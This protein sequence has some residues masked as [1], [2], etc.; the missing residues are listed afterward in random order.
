MDNYSF[1]GTEEMSVHLFPICLLL[2]EYLLSLRRKA[3]RRQDML[4]VTTDCSIFSTS[5]ADTRYLLLLFGWY[6]I[7]CKY[8]WFSCTKELS[9]LKK[10]A[11]PYLPWLSPSKVTYLMSFFLLVSE[12]LNKVTYFGVLPFTTHSP[13][14]SSGTRQHADSGM[15]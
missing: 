12:I 7:F 9:T 5:R 1:C 6:K 10:E 11:R 14:M 13:K 2:V 4:I 8:L 15:F 3:N